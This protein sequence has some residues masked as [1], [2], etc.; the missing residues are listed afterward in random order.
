[1]LIIERKINFIESA[2]LQY[3][4]L[5]HEYKLIFVEENYM[6]M[7]PT[8]LCNWNKISQPV[9]L[10]VDPYQWT[11]SFIISVTNEKI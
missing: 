11:I 3:Y 1:M 9:T 4:L 7:K 8:I 6:N 10:V 2:Y 5:L